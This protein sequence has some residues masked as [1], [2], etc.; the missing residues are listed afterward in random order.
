MFLGANQDSYAAGDGL[1]VHA[2]NASNFDASPYG[3]QA[4]YAGLNRTVTEWRGKGRNERRRDRDDFWGGVKEA[5]DA[6]R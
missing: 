4:T 2:G 6:S 5:E 1:S 3:V